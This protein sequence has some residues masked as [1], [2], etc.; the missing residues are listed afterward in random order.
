MV[1]I[2]IKERKMCTR[3]LIEMG[4]LVAKAKLDHLPTNILLGS[5]LCLKKYSSIASKCLRSLDYNR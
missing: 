4:R 1:D 3:R 2:T 5:L